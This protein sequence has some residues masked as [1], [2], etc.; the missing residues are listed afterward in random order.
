MGDVIQT[1]P[2]KPFIKAPEL[3]GRYQIVQQGNEPIIG[4][5]NGNPCNDYKDVV[6]FGDHTLSLHKPKTPF[7]IATDG[8]RI[9]KGQQVTDGYYLLSLLERY[10]PQNEGYKRYYNILKNSNCRTICDIDEQKQIGSLFSKLDNLITLEQEK[11]KKLIRLSREFYSN[12]FSEKSKVSSEKYSK[13]KLSDITFPYDERA[14]NN[15]YPLL[16]S[17]LSGIFLQSEY[18]DNNTASSDVYNYK[19]VPNG[20]FTYRSMS[21]TGKFKINLQNI[22][23]KGIVSP[24]YPVFKLSDSV[25]KVYFEKYIEYSPEIQYKISAS[26]QGGTRLALPFTKLQNIEMFL[27]SLEDQENISDLIKL[28]DKMILLSENKILKLQSLKQFLLCNL[29][30]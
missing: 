1:I 7:F 14:K 15:S 8:V 3:K 2:F 25:N 27:H 21:D 23:E 19:V 22:V 9:I 29:F 16:S 18:F 20:Y 5:A 24:A 11:H 12:I 10:R 4:Y 17:T 28:I 30:I 26:A 13:V 6:I